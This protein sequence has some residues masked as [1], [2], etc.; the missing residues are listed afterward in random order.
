M[1]LYITRDKKDGDDPD[2]LFLHIEK[3]KIDFSGSMWEGVADAIPDVKYGE[4][5]RIQI[6]GIKRE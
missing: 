6:S 3:P 5:K 1:Y 2:K 4:C